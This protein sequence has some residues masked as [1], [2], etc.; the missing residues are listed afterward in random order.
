M[1][2]NAVQQALGLSVSM[3]LLLAPAQLLADGYHGNVMTSRAPE[4]WYGAGLQQLSAAIPDLEKTLRAAPPSESPTSQNAKLK[5]ARDVEE[6][7]NRAASAIPAPQSPAANTPAPESAPSTPT[8]GGRIHSEFTPE[9]KALLGRASSESLEIL[10]YLDPRNIF[11]REFPNFPVERVPGYR[12]AAKRMLLVTGPVGAESVVQALRSE[13][14]GMGGAG[15][16]GMTHHPQ[17][18][19]DLLEALQ[20]AAA[21]GYLAP[22]HVQ[23][24]QQAAAGAKPEPQ[25]ALAAEVQRL[26]PDLENVGPGAILKWA[27]ETQDPSRRQDLYSRVDR[28]IPAASTEELLQASKLIGENASTPQAKRLKQ[29]TNNEIARRAASGTLNDLL[30]LFDTDI[31]LDARVRQ[32]AEAALDDRLTEADVAALLAAA[33]HANPQV[34]Q[35][36]QAALAQ[37]SPTYAEVKDLLPHIWSHAESSDDAVADAARRQAANAFQRA[38]ISHCLYWLG[39]VES[40]QKALIWTQIDARIARADAPRRAEYRQTALHVTGL[41]KAGL[42]SRLAALD[43]LSRLKD[44][45]AARPL[46]DLLPLLPRECWPA[47]GAAL[48]AITGQDFGPRRGDGGAEVGVAVKKWRVWLTEN[49]Q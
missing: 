17:Y 30:A 38:P 27:S 10:A 26:L 9:Q 29:Q 5:V 8:A 12:L 28:W 21:S 49:G 33:A 47:A 20:D 40:D 45:Q 3:V 1:I 23:T 42:A 35:P 6:L 48:S 32:S 46:V 24:L 7:R 22:E 2:P 25:A 16:L 36:A 11:P 4:A 31:E 19:T 14:M 13:L 44:P 18:Y 43:L 37:R 15:V 41:K 39:V 34:S